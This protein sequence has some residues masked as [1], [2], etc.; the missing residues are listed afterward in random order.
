M[1]KFKY[2][3]D[4]AI[5]DAAFEAYGKTLED[6]FSTCA[7]ATFEVMADTKKIEQKKTIKIK[8]K[9]KDVETLL[10]DFLSELIYIKDKERM[11]F[12]KFDLK[13]E[14]GKVYKLEGK[15]K[16]EKTD[17]GKHKV[18]LDVKAVTYHLFEVKRDK[19]KWR[20]KIILDV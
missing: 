8:L 12:N 13:I 3:D 7:F 15:L 17:Q 20:A 9:A 10:F 14:Q 1:G 11:L 16:G 2:L 4:V 19:N 5:A 18:R 6:L